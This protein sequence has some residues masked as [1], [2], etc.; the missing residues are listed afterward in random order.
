MLKG[1]Y[2]TDDSG[3]IDNSI[4]LATHTYDHFV[5]TSTTQI[6]GGTK[7]FTDYVSMSS[8]TVTGTWKRL[9][10]VILAASAASISINGINGN[11]DLEMKVNYYI[12]NAVNA[13]TQFGFTLNGDAGANY[14]QMNGQATSGAMTGTRLVNQNRIMCGD[15]AAINDE[16]TGEFTFKLTASVATVAGTTNNYRTFIGHWGVIDFANVQTLDD[17]STS[18]CY[19]VKTGEI[20]TIQIVNS[21]G[22][23]LGIG[24][25]ME[26]SVRR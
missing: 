10:Y 4:M 12:K 8:A 7:T 25:Y 16:I 19:T 24:S 22:G 20:T 2:D 26:V 11:T 3:I 21:V 6:I 17:T 23:N 15:P 9:N 14:Q 1:I 18:G 13:G 5:T